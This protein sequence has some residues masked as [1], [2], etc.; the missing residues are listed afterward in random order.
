MKLLFAL[1]LSAGAVTAQA[2]ECTSWGK[3]GKLLH[4]DDFSGKLGRWHSEI[5][6]K[7]D[8]SVSINGKKLLIDVGGGATVWFRQALQGDV[9][10]T[11]KRK[12]LVGAGK[13]DR[14]SDLNM[15]WMA[16]DPNKDSLFTRKGEFSEYDGLR[17]YYAGIGGNTNTTTRLRRYG[18]G[19]RV[20]HAD[21]GDQAHLLEANKE[22]AVQIAV[23]RGCTRVLVNGQEYF[24]YRDPAPLRHGHFGFRTTQSRQEI[25]DFKVFELR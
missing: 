4:A 13:N 17:M 21:L 20:L 19:E 16:T 8:S 3:Q 15:F 18:D 1:L 7:G 5:E 11:F 10:I 22:Y 6:Q 23:Y 25:D 12:V 9:L 14:L 2:Q 24:Q